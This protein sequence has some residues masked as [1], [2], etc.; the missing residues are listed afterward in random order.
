[1]SKAVGYGQEPHVAKV[2]PNAEKGMTIPLLRMFNAQV[3][4]HFYTTS[5]GERDNAVQKLGYQSEGVTGHVFKT[6][7]C[8]SVPLHRLYNPAAKNHFYT[9]SEPEAN[10]AA[11]ALGYQREGVAGFV[12]PPQ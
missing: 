3:K 5:E 9:T 10:N 4:D 12:L 6:Q 7:I 2:F 8:G 11:V 1:M